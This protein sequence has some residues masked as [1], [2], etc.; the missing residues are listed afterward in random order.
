LAL[1]DND[2]CFV[3]SRCAIRRAAIRRAAIRRAAIRRAAIRPLRRGASSRRDGRGRIA[4][5]R[6]TEETSS[7]GTLSAAAHTTR[8]AGDKAH[9]AAI[10]DAAFARTR[11]RAACPPN[12]ASSTHDDF[13]R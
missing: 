1:A 12:T 10:D 4:I 3:T 5:R 7:A 11:R 9:D 13:G 8:G 6:P 2:V